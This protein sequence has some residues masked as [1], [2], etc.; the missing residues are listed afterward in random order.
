M[1]RIP[2]NRYRKC[3]ITKEENSANIYGIIAAVFFALVFLGLLLLPYLATA[4]CQANAVPA[5]FAYSTNTNPA[6]Y[7]GSNTLP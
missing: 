6:K 2:R 4:I 7:R 5:E 3:T 1:K